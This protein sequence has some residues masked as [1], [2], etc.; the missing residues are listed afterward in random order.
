MV[1]ETARALAEKQQSSLSEA[2][3]KYFMQA[4]LWHARWV[5]S[6]YGKG[7]LALNKGM[8]QQGRSTNIDFLFIGCRK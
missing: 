3:E 1:D 6:V 8:S 5:P 2:L 7:L 4:A